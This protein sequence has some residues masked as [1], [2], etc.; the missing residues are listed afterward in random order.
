VIKGLKRIDDFSK[1]IGIVFFAT[2]F[3]NF[4]NLL[5]QLFIAHQLTAAE[6]AAFNSLLSLFVWLSSPL[7][8]L[9]TAVGKF[10]SEFSANKDPSKTSGLLLG[11][12]KKS[13]LG[14]VVVFLAFLFAGPFITAKLKI[15]SCSSG[16]FLAGLLASSCLSPI[17]LGGLQGLEKFGWYAFVLILTAALKLAL[18]FLFSPSGL[19]ISKALAALLLASLAG[20]ALSIL[21]FKGILFLKAKED[22]ETSRKV[23]A[24]LFPVAVSLFLFM[25]LVNMDMVLVKYFFSGTDSGYYSLA[26]MA[27]KVFFYLPASISFVMLPKTSGLEAKN[28]DTGPILRR[29][30]FYGFSLCL[31]A[32]LFYNLFP[33]FTIRLL[34][35]K[36][37]PE[38]ILLGRFF[39]VSM[40]FFSMF[41]ILMT[42][43]LSVKDLRFIKILAAVAVLQFAAIALFHEKLIQVQVTLCLSSLFLFFAPL[44]LLKN[45]F[46]GVFGKN[47]RD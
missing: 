18:S 21:P 7:M 38:S 17:L 25:S 36:V 24:Y 2:A 12:F 27:G 40:T 8:T 42:Y 43:F 19:N 44:V 47:G 28:M 31:T 15:S 3:F 16:F 46:S 6:F 4:L 32:A 29:S 10:G 23:F 11:L 37:F 9:Q 45:K 34:T 13:V 14:A 26:Q 39:S 1:N 33:A 35:G 41:F 30:L 20:I 22:K 5:Y